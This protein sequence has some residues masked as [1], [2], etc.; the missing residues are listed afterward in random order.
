M[1]GRR[2]TIAL[3]PGP[4]DQHHLHRDVPAGEIGPTAGSTPARRPRRLPHEDDWGGWDLHV[5]Q[6][7]VALDVP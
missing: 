3:H 5:L 1:V 4:I 7:G 2:R 6:A